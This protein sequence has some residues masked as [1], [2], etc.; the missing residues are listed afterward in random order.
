MKVR[1]SLVTGLIITLLVLGA[2]TV[3]VWI[4]LWVREK[5]RTAS[6][7]G[8]KQLLSGLKGPIVIPRKT[9]LIVGVISAGFLLGNAALFSLGSQPFDMTNEKVWAYVGAKYGPLELYDLPN[10]VSLAKAWG[11]TP[12]HEA[13]LP[14][15]FVFAYFFAAIGWLYRMFLSGSGPLL[16]DTF[17]LEFLIKSINIIFALLD[18]LLIFLIL[19]ELKVSRR[20]ALLSMCLFLFNP[21]VWFVMSIW[22]Q[23]YSVSIFLLLLSIWF[24][25]RK[26]AF[27]AWFSLAIMGLT[28]PQMLVPAFLL[29]V[30]FLRR[31]SPR[32][33]VEAI[34]WSI[35]V[36]FL[37]LGP[38]ALAISPSLPVDILVNT[39][40]VQPRGN[41][42]LWNAVSLDAYSVWTLVTYFVGGAKG[43]ARIFYPSVAP[44]IGPI[45]YR[46]LSQILTTALILFLAG[47]L[48]VHRKAARDRYIPIV[49]L[50]TL[51]LLVLYTGFSSVHFVIGLPLLVLCRKSMDSAVYY[52][53][54]AIWTV[55]T[56]VPMYG[57]FGFAI[58]GVGYLAPAL[59]HSS[60]AITHL[61]MDLFSSDRFMTLGA[62][63]NVIALLWLLCEALLFGGS[64]AER[65]DGS[66]SEQHRG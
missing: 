66:S 19:R 24:L 58:A 54:I 14:Y 31:F 7:V 53:V 36:A 20:T 55:T 62:A 25:E 16:L 61:F 32:E 10:T 43:L 29:G 52:T 46:Q 65:V 51:S 41:E 44:L 17:Q 33:N 8:V 2:V 9:V 5:V 27:P 12:R 1:D 39:L 64:S 18:G 28:R 38:F 30:V 11:G 42:A 15:E 48:L 37:F 50:G 35:V 49:A 26:K 56:F 6:G 63:A 47:I 45:T 34:S 59:H 57:I 22:G 60:N 3:T 21:A 13:V 40:L 23:T 4:A